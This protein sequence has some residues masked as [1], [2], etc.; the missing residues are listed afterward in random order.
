MNTKHKISIPEPCHENWDK[1]I[2][3]DNGRFCLN[4]SKTVV[5]FTKMLPEEIQQYFVSNQNQSICGRFK[6]SQLDEITIQIPSRILYSQTNYHKMFLL[7]LFIAM[8]T[9]LFSC[10][11][12]N[13]DKQKI[14]KVEV[15]EEENFVTTGVALPP[16]HPQHL[17]PSPL[18]NVDHVKFV[19]TTSNINTEKVKS[20]KPSII[21][22]GEKIVKDS[23][24][25]DDTII[26]GAS[27]EVKANYPG[28][29]TNFRDFFLKEFKFPE[30]AANSKSPI[31][32]S[33]VIE[34]D[35]SLSNIDFP[36][37]IDPKIGTEITRVLTLSPKWIPGEQNGKKTR[38]KYSFPISFQ[39]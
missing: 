6:K 24:V 3:K 30:E 34:R 32:V 31:I 14:D 20:E 13:G 8:G 5:D 21:S 23:I 38:E 39:K 9:T 16:K 15:T 12:K 26:M 2:P 22:C 1:M 29:I 25:E 27:I 19:K 28:G 33:F 35:G 36:K 37:D 17:V 7:A 18:Q 10:T 11:D 4:C